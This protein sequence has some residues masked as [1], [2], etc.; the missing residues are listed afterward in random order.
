MERSR[1]RRWFHHGR[2]WRL[3]FNDGR[4]QANVEWQA[5]RPSSLLSQYRR[6]IHL[7][8][9]SPALRNGSMA[10]LDAGEGNRQLLAFVRE[11]G[12]ERVLVV[13]NL[14]LTAVTAGPWDLHASEAKLLYATAGGATARAKGDTRVTIPGA[15]GDLAVE[16]GY[17]PHSTHPLTTETRCSRLG[18][19]VR[20]TFASARSCARRSM[21]FAGWYGASDDDAGA[22]RDP[23]R[24]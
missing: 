2:P 16:V 11:A 6:L 10:V 12:G 5:E 21:A 15:L 17:R 24:H 22:A 9:S 4:A 7:R 18:N 20:E 1:T 19:S 23:A 8:A 13:H 14:G 3:P